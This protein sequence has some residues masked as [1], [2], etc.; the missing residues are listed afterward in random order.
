MSNIEKCN[1]NTLKE[2][3][4]NSS[5][6]GK[7]TIDIT[8]SEWKDYI[9]IKQLDMHCDVCKKSRQLFN[10]V[11][12]RQ[13]NANYNGYPI[14]HIISDVNNKL[15]IFKFGCESCDEFIK[16]IIIHYHFNE[17][18]L[19]LV[20]AGEYPRKRIE[21]D[22][23]L[24]N[25]FKEDI[26]LY[27]KAIICIQHNF[28]IAAYAYLRRI[29]ENNIDRLLEQL[30]LIIDLKPSEFDVELIKESFNSLKN[31]SPMSNKIALAKM[32]LP[33]HLSPNGENPLGALY[34]ALSDGVHS[35]SDEKCLEKAGSILA[36][37]KYLVG[38]IATHNDHKTEYLNSLKMVNK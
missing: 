26:D 37:L 16:E 10:K 14:Q 9:Y 20:K 5:Q 25:F 29:I 28:G 30:K 12:P 27:E 38:E 35:L 13:I 19:T 1:K 31:T 15:N 21:R 4:E 3:F 23:F 6:Y 22:K 18:I 7:I 8:D 2:F 33:K 11:T 32:N 24:S 34:R 36:V 17:E